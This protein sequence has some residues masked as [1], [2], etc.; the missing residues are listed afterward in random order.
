MP[1]SQYGALN[2]SALVVPNVY[3]QIV[4]PTTQYLNGLPTNILGGVGSASWGPTNSPVIAGTPAQAAAIF[5]QPVARKYDLMTHVS[6]AALQGASNFKLVRVTDGTDV[7]S[8]IV[9]LTNCITFNSKYTGSFGNGIVVSLAAG[10]ATGSQQV[11][12]SAPGLIPEVFGNIGVGL[13]GNALWVA[14]AAAINT[15]SGVLRPGSNIITATAG[16]GTTAPVVASYSLAGG[17]DGATSVTATMLI[18]SDTTSPR[19]GMYALRNSQ[20]SVA[21]LADCDTSTTWPTQIAYGLSE[22][23]Y[24]IMTGPSGDTLANAITTKATAGIDSYAGKLMFGDWLYWLDPVNGLRVVSP[25]GYVAG[26]LSNLSPAL[27]TLNAQLYGVAGTQKTM[28]NQVYAQADLQALASVGID[29][30]ANP[31]P[32]GSYFSCFLGHNTSSNPIIHDD[33]Y[34][35]LTNYIA[36]T[37]SGGMGKYIGQL[38][39]PTVQAQA[40]GTLN[41]FFYTLWQQGLIGNPNNATALPY[42]VNLSASN[43]SLAR[44]ALGYLQADIQVEYYP[45]I[46]FFLINTQ[47]GASVQITRQGLSL[48]V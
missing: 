29:C 12:V 27:G 36:Y 4:P 35:R 44:E 2:T 22:G 15:G 21:F 32:G 20:A 18:G 1:V 40:S 13:S 11:T 48:A 23:T 38:N 30:I 19:T 41:S 3:V 24:M 45:I 28:A 5:G 39:T 42:S 47:G 17:T 16:V 31:S 25:Q 14:I 43:N 7:A 26:L 8:T 33:S 6:T 10:N 9:A 46:E 34:T 37:I